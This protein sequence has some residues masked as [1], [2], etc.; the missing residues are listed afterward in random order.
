MKTFPKYKEG[1]PVRFV[2]TRGGR[3]GNVYECVIVKL[4]YS[5]EV[6]D[7]QTRQ[8]VTEHRYSVRAK[9][10]EMFN[11][12]EHMLTTGQLTSVEATNLV[13]Q[14]Q[15]FHDQHAKRREVYKDAMADALQQRVEAFQPGDLVSYSPGNTLPVKVRVVEVLKEAGKLK[16]ENW[17]A[18]Y[19]PALGRRTKN[20][21]TVWANRCRKVM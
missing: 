4:M 10:G 11:V 16:I 9:S 3:Q 15:S 8:K 13:E 5:R 21:V 6:L 2:S 18:S 19:A 17:K 7:P 1:D 20:T 14:G 12:S